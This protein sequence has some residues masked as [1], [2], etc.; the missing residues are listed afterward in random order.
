MNAFK[1][2]FTYFIKCTNIYLYLLP[3]LLSCRW[4]TTTTTPTIGTRQRP[5]WT[6]AAVTGLQLWAVTCTWRGGTTARASWAAQR[7]SARQGGSGAFLWPWTRGAAECRWCRPRG[8][9]TRWVA[10]TGSPTS[11]RWRCTTPTPT[12]GPS[13]PPWAAMRGG[14]G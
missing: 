8:A 1:I 9:C 14:L 12:D 10:T 2:H 5:W 4:S 13:G 3:L 7:C 11:A 6:N